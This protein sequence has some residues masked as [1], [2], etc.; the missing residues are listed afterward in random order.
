MFLL[1]S[2]RPRVPRGSPLAKGNRWPSPL[3]T[4]PGS[5]L[6]ALPALSLSLSW[7]LPRRLLLSSP[8]AKV[9]SR[10]GSLPWRW[11]WRGEG[12]TGIQQVSEWP[13]SSHSLVHFPVR[14]TSGSC[15]ASGHREET[16]KR[17]WIMKK[18]K[19][20][21]LAFLPLIVLSR[22]TEIQIE[23]RRVWHEAKLPHQN[24]TGD[25]AIGHP[26]KRQLNKKRKQMNRE[27]QRSRVEC[28]WWG[29]QEKE[30][31]VKRNKVIR[32]GIEFEGSKNGKNNAV[33]AKWKLLT[34]KEC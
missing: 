28:W 17:D 5:E 32:E 23:E 2:P 12:R 31:W 21:L 11:R 1:R 29:R 20:C 34:S 6:P 30:K 33:Q 7:S 24:R 8:G 22:A 14:A 27:Q 4:T 25:A 16:K 9:E 26:K 15:L 3:T 10:G 18:W 13:N 19:K